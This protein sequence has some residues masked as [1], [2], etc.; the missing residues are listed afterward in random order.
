MEDANGTKSYGGKKYLKQLNSNATGS[1][2]EFPNPCPAENNT[3]EFETIKSMGNI[4]GVFTGHDHLNDYTG[5]LDGVKLTAVPGMTYFNYGDEAVR[6]YGVIEL[7][8]ADLSTYDYHTVKFS[9]L[10]AEA[11]GTTETV[12]DV[13]DE[14]GYA[15]L[16][17]NGSALPATDYNIHG[18]NTFTYNATSPSKSAIFRFRWTAGADT[19]I[20]F[21]FD[22]G[23]NGNCAYPFAVWVKKPN[24]GSAGVNGAWHL[25]PNVS[26]TLVNMKKAIKQGDTFDIEL[27][28][29]KVLSG[30]PVYLGQY[31]VYLKVNGTL[32][33][34]GY[35]NTSDDGKF[36]SGDALCQVS[37]EIR[38]GDWS[39]NDNNNR[40]SAYQEP[41]PEVEP[42]EFASYDI[43]EYKDLKK[44]GEALAVDGTVL[45]AQNNPFTYT[46]ASPTHSAIYR[47][48]WV[49]GTC[50]YFQ[51]YPGVYCTNPFMYRI[52]ASSAEWVKRYD[53]GIASKAIGHAV[54]EGDEFDIEIGRLMVSGGPNAGK[55][56]TYFKVDDEVIFEEYV[57]ES[58]ITDERAL[59]DGI[60]FNLNANDYTCTIKAIPE[61]EAEAPDARYYAYDEITYGDLHLNGSSVPSSGYNLTG[62][63]TF[64]YNATSAT[65]STVF[66][67]RWKTGSVAKF[68]LS[69]DTT[70]AD[71]SGSVSFPFCA[72][73]KYPNQPGFGAEAGPNGAWHL[74]PSNNSTKVD[75]EEPLV[76]GEIYDVEFGRLK[77]KNGDHAGEYYVY[78]K[79]D[80]VLVNSYYYAS[81]GADGSY[82]DTK[83]SNF[84]RFEVYNT[85]GT[86]ISDIPVP[87]TYED[88][89][90]IGFDSLFK[91]NE[92]MAGKTLENGNHHFT[93]SAASSSYSMKL[94]FRWT[95]GGEVS[96]R[97][98]TVF[99]D[100]WVYPFC[101]AAKAPNQSGFGATAGPN[102]SWHLVPSNGS[103]IVDM[104]EPIE[105]GRSYD[106][107]FGRLKVKTGNPSNIGKYYV[108]VMVDGELIQSYYYDGVDDNA[109][110]GTPLSNK[111]IIAVPAGNSISAVPVPVTYEPYDEIDY[112]DL[113]RNGEP[114]AEG[115]TSLSGGT[116]FTYE[117]TS[118]TGSAIFRFNW[119]I[120]S[121]PKIQLSFEKTAADAMAYM[122]GAWLSEPGADEGFDNGRMWLR[123]SYGP[124]ADMPW[125]LAAGSSHNVEFAR[126]KLKTGQNT[127][128]YHVYIR[129]DDVLIAE[130]YVAAGVV[131]SG[132]EYETRPEIT[133]CN[134]KSGE[135]FFAF[136]G[137]EGNSISPYKKTAAGD[138][139][140]IRGDFDNDGSFTAED[141]SA[142]RKVI[143][144]ALN[145]DELPEGIADFNGDGVINL[146]DIIA[147]MKYMALNPTETYARSAALK[148][149]MQE[150]LL[151]DATKTAAY[152]AD[153]TAVMG[154]DV[155][156]L[157]MPIHQL[158]YADASNKAVVR[159]D[160]MA[161]FKGMV[162]ELK[163][164]GIEEILYVTDSFILPYGYG[165]AANNHNITVPDPQSDKE[166]YLAWLKVNS[167]A[168][169]K[170]AA[171]VPEIRFFEPYN[172]I[173]L[174]GTRMERYGI[175]WNASQADQ[176]THKFTVQEKAGIMADLC[177]YI[178]AAVK[179]A[180]PANQVTTPSISAQTTA[181]VET[182]FLEAFYTAI[183]TGAYPT[184]KAVGDMR[185][186]NFFTIVN[187]HAYP[188]YTATVSQLQS[189]A[190][191]FAANLQ[192]AYAVM[193]RHGDGGSPVWLT[194][195]G[196]SSWN[197]N[198]TARNED[199]AA[200]LMR[201][202]LEKT[203]SELTFIDTVILYKLA[204]I[205]SDLGAS[206]VET[207]YGLFYSGDDLDHDPYTAKPVAKTVY[208]FFHNGSTDYSALEALAGR[209]E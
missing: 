52:N 196:V 1:L 178:S 18:S 107:E 137:S 49:A 209:Y 197:G 73:A 68:S 203:D 2:N 20:Q 168:F 45:T 200:T 177:W 157:S 161:K 71:G 134:V 3:G 27:G 64:T 22:V 201:L 113:S 129:I 56:Y 127:G 85:E 117:P 97:R 95:A 106:I 130:D 75:M 194:E 165:D 13:Y 69:F 51:M 153:A 16:R 63:K 74:D 160:N 37:N 152:I 44:D 112:A 190:N 40:I 7:D 163:A 59:G 147:M 155:Y 42:D 173:N 48:R 101:F 128:K 41:V 87:E 204:D 205:S 133:Y 202:V 114:L 191:S 12:Y 15:D 110:A 46:A 93:Y 43:I 102:G 4:L 151:E 135:I 83:L 25:K 195:T 182:A 88:Y 148:L 143:A 33:Q 115:S 111:I 90:E 79:V 154:A 96:D 8:E 14:I 139:E 109:Y 24:Q 55:Y 54:S 131:D 149:G 108:Y 58:E 26:S 119:K 199:T 146:I 17:K 82:K 76:P 175:G 9:T 159:T 124:Q 91:D 193:Q 89:D 208:S 50:T 94:K 92:S 19:G 66:R 170:L 145:T 10:D 72:V 121:V 141:V 125:I 38:F 164:K 100:D 99:L 80:D 36:R 78:L 132:G 192:N 5:T 6:G 166:N 179:A 167:E 186:D 62:G 28:R 21:S 184:G 61:E 103:M 188:E 70:A 172:E 116:V 104:D 84:I 123:P 30:D 198:G 86:Q 122:F 60:Q 183:G 11:G 39:S 171:E 118:P 140:A 174:T 142:L 31:Y 150:H 156:R 34:E 180:D 181:T 136:W 162:S 138:H 176:A 120:G 189:K 53:P 47:F 77:V 207:G 65:Y 57:S 169:G 35:S 185:V 81:V 206:A 98:I 144:G 158:Y 29:L 23:E 126:L 105:V 32:V 187:L 67:F